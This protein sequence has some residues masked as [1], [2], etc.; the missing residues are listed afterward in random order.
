MNKHIEIQKFQVGNFTYELRLMPAGAVSLSLIDGYVPGIGSI[1][2]A[3]R[4][5]DPFERWDEYDPDDFGLV[6]DQD[7]DV[8]VFQLTRECVN[9]ISGW[10]N[11]VKPGYFI[12]SP[13]TDRKEP[14]YDRFAKIIGRKVKGYTSQKIRRGHHFYRIG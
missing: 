6:D 2:K 11:R 4:K 7:F 14:V 8:P 5:R 1:R 9:R 3:Y 13:S 12:I 10:A